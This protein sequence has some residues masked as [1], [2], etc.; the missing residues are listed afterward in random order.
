MPKLPIEVTK[1][2]AAPARIAGIAS[3]T[4]IDRVTRN[5]P[6]PPSRA[7]S[8]RSRGR[9]RSPARTARNTSVECSIPI[10]STMPHLE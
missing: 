1:A 9:W 8:T 7:A 5:G 6:A 10:T 4:I 2:S 3:G